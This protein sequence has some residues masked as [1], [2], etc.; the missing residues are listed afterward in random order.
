MWM[1]GADLLHQGYIKLPKGVTI[2]WPDSG[3]GMIRDEGHVEA[4]QGIY[5]HTAMLS[6]QHNQLSE[7]VNPGRI[8]N[9]VGRFIRAGATEFFLVNVS[10]IRPVPLSTDCVMKLVWNAK[11]YMGKTDEENM[12]AFLLDWSKR[13]FGTDLAGKIAAIYKQY[14]AI[15][16]M[17][18]DVLK[19]EN[20][21]HT[22]LRRLNALVEPLMADAKMLTDE[23]LKSAQEN[24]TF[25][26]SAAAYVG[27]LLD[28]AKLVI[29]QLPDD[30]AN[31][32]QSHVITEI[33]IHL[34]SLLALEWYCKS[35]LAYHSGDKTTAV[36]DAENAVRSCNDLFSA[37]HQ[38]EYGKWAG[39][40][41]GECFVNLNGSYDLVRVLAA[42]M[43]G[44]PL[45]PTRKP[46]TYEDLYK[47][48]ERFEKNFPLLYPEK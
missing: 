11:P 29:P 20:S 40:Y 33:Q 19:G 17:R 30:R 16:Y 3:E 5:Y 12:D 2:V 31:F 35:V 46:R 44:E 23:A 9:Q 18:D 1:E 22:R 41:R 24:L 48:Q 26:N 14:Y 7:M 27:D 25:S 43:K 13:E 37:L 47:Y 28:K 6:S 45:P 21:I 8:Y 36:A 32:Y 4:G 38:A 34:Q 15:P 39:W 42:R 10:D